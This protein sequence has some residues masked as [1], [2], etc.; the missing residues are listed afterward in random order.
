MKRCAARDHKLRQVGRGQ[1]G[2][3][4]LCGRLQQHKKKLVIISVRDFHS[5][6]QIKLKTKLG[7]RESEWR[8]LSK[9]NTSRGPGAQ[10]RPGPTWLIS[11]FQAAAEELSI[12][13]AMKQQTRLDK[14]QLNMNAEEEANDA[15]WVSE[16]AINEN[17][18][19]T[20]IVKIHLNFYKLNRWRKATTYC[21]EAATTTNNNN[22]NNKR[23]LEMWK[24]N[25]SFLFLFLQHFCL[26]L[27]RQPRLMN[28]L[29]RKIYWRLQKKQLHNEFTI[30]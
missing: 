14:L 4:D 22:K 24:L 9:A 21:Q 15:E 12:R 29:R 26:W 18:S 5:Y 1:R 20:D 19:H 13:H 6:W 28:C 7:G 2:S 10:I 27:F 23:L 25:F 11:T 30:N 3:L 8:Q 16:R 17:Y